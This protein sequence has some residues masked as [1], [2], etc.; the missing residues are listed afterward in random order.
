ME[1]ITLEGQSFLDLAIQGGSLEAI[2]KIDSTVSITDDPVIGKKY[3]I[4]I[5]NSPIANYY[6]NN[7]IFP[8]SITT[9]EEIINQAGGIGA[10][11]IGTSFI[12]R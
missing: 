1:T 10:M 5:V 12:V 11:A 3:S 8:A 2:F 7:Q 9:Q 6:K 4:E